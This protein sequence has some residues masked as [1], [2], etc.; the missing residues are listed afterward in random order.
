MSF[1]MP[2]A[3]SPTPIPVPPPAATPATLANPQAAVSGQNQRARAAAAAGLYGGDG[4]VLTS[5]QGTTAA[6]KL[7]GATL[8]SGAQ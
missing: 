7:A 1:L 2:S 6:P 8:L 3:P 5:P 4:T